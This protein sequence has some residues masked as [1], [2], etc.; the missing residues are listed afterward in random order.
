MNFSLL[1]SLLIKMIKDIDPVIKFS[2]IEIE[3]NLNKINSLFIW[4]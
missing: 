1:K 4:V 2:P 3:N